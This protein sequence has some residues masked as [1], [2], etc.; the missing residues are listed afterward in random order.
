[1]HVCTRMYVPCSHLHVI[2]S[3][4]GTFILPFW[5]VVKPLSMPS[6]MRAGDLGQFF[7]AETGSTPAFN[8]TGKFLHGV[9]D[10]GKPAISTCQGQTWMRR[11]YPLSISSPAK[12]ESVA[13][14]TI[15]PR[16]TCPGTPKRN[17]T[18]CCIRSARR[19]KV[20]CYTQ[21]ESLQLEQGGGLLPAR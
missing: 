13:C 18:Y 4:H 14:D 21:T 1:M 7:L 5:L 9:A 12:P 2:T 15:L 8:S 11:I 3:I 10:P 16:K 20:Y 6:V 17:T 19:H